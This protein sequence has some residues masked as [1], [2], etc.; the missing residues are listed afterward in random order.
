VPH[1]ADLDADGDIDLL[2]GNRIAPQADTTALLTWFENAGTRTAPAFRARGPLPMRGEYHYAPTVVDLDG[3]GR[4][5]LALGTWRD[6][7]QWWRNTGTAAVPR[8]ALADSALVTLTRGSNTTPAFTDLDGDGDQDLVVG[9]ASGQL[10]L[11]RNEGSATAP[12][13]V[14]VTDTLEGIDVGRRST[15]AFADLD[16]DGVVELVVGS[17]DG[18]LQRWRTVREGDWVRFVREEGVRV[19]TYSYSAP[20]FGDLDGDGRPDLVLGTASGGLLWFG[21]GAR[22]ASLTR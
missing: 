13:F 11:Y 22:R 17:E 14:L 10:N 9:E 5:D 3:D 15:P 8:Y 4:S 6:K 18:G 1:L 12:R 19:E 16:G 20:A 7:V 2:V 21:T